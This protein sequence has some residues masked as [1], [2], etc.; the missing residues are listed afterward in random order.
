M[1]ICLSC[2]H[3]Q[4]DDDGVAIA[5]QHGF[6]PFAGC[7]PAQAHRSGAVDRGGVV[8]RP[9]VPRPEHAASV[10]LVGQLVGAA[11]AE[12][13]GTRI[14]VHVDRD[15]IGDTVRDSFAHLLSGKGAFVRPYAQQEWRVAI[16]PE[17]GL[18]IPGDVSVVSMNNSQLAQHM[19]PPLT[20]VDAFPVM[21]GRQAFQ[22][23]QER[24][25]GGYDGP[26]RYIYLQ[27]RLAV[28]GSSGAAA[29][30]ARTEA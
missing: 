5:A 21:L 2:T 22:R 25:S 3:R 18:D 28:R 17:A 11:P 1:N 19:E 14:G 8:R 30:P 7:V 23:L 9:S 4:F 6:I 20:S 12:D 10:R 24:M 29:A 15:V 26:A 16:Q 13:I 27:P